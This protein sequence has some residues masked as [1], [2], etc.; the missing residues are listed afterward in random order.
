MGVEKSYFNYLDVLDIYFKEL[1]CS[2]CEYSTAW[3]NALVNH[4]KRIHKK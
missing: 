1:N 2:Q 4:I 3:K